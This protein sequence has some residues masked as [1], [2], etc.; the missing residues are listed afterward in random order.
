MCENVYSLTETHPDVR[1]PSSWT[2]SR[3]NKT[4]AT[5][6]QSD[7]LAAIGVHS[8]RKITTGLVPLHAQFYVLLGAAKT[9]VRSRAQAKEGE[10]SEKMPLAALPRSQAVWYAISVQSHKT[11]W[12]SICL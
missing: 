10:L 9:T 5:E 12:M 7:L 1:R 2:F 4:E 3:G 6:F 8:R 11:T